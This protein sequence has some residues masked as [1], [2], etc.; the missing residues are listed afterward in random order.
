MK[1]KNRIQV[2]GQRGLARAFVLAPVVF[3][4]VAGAGCPSLFESTTQRETRVKQA[5]VGKDGAYTVP[6]GNTV[7]NVYAQLAGTADPVAGDKSITVTD[8]NGDFL[9]AVAQGD[10]L[11]IVQMAGATIDTTESAT[12]GA[13]TDL[14]SAGRYEFIGVEGKSG[15]TITLACAL[16][17]GYSRAG[18][19]QVIR[20]PQYTTLTVGGANSITAPAW[21]GVTGGVVAVHAETT[22]QLAGTI[23][24]SAK[25]FRGGAAHDS[26]GTTGLA[27][28]YRSTDATTAAEKGESI[29][30]YEA[31]YATG[32]YG[33]GAPANGGGGGGSH[34]AGGGGG[35]NAGDPA[36]YAGGLGVMLVDPTVVGGTL[37]WPLE[38]TTLAN[39][40][41]GGRGGYSYSANDLNGT[42]AAGAPGLAGWGGDSRRV[43]GGLGGHPLANNPASRLFMGGG[44]G[45][46][47]GNDGAAGR[48]G[49]GGGLVFL[50]T[51][52]VT[53]AGSI[54]ADGEAGGNMPAGTANGDAAG[55]GGGG[56]T[57]VVRATTL[58]AITI[59]ADGGKGGDHLGSSSQTEVEGPGGGGGGGYIAL[60]GTGSPTLSAAGGLSGTTT[61]TALS[62]F[63]CDGATVGHAGQT[64]GSA[65]TF[66]YCGVMPVTTIA[67]HPTNPSKTDTGA[68]TFTN[69]VT[70]V[71][72]ECMVDSGAWAACTASFTTGTLADGSHTLSVRATDSNSNREAPPA[73]FTWVI[74]TVAPDTTIATKPTDPS[75]SATG[76]FTFTSNESPV[77][78]ECNL[79][80]G[81]WAACTASTTTPAL[82]NG[83]HT[84]SV[85]ATDAAGNVDA[86]PASYTWVINA[87]LPVTTIANKP[88]NPSKSPTGDFTFTNT[89]NP[90][91]YECKIDTG[92]WASCGASYTTPTLADGSH[93]L[94]VRSSQTVTDAGSNL[95][96]PPV[97]Y[98]WIID[99][100]APDTTIATKPSNPS[101]GS[102]GVFTFESNETPVTFECKLDSGAWALCTASYTTPVLADGSHTLEV[103][104]TDAAKNVDATPA[105][106]TWMV[107]ASGLDGGA[108][109]AGKRDAVAAIDAEPI[110]TV[111]AEPVD[112]GKID[113]QGVD[114]AA[115]RDLGPVLD[116]DKVDSVPADLR[117]DVQAT[118]P[119]PGP[120]TA[121]APTEP[122]AD[123]AVVVKDDAAEPTGNKDA[124]IE[125]V[126]E[127]I[128]IMGGGFCSVASSPATSAA[129]F[130]F[131]FALTGLALLR[132]RR[133]R[134]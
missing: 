95:E 82:P 49:R 100:V 53:G 11:L 56:G 7:V 86:T 51:G 75:A 112:T 29:A 105:T 76:A 107:D 61:R 6:A 64:N 20:V 126:T 122:P 57:V 42:L 129:P 26:R 19:T 9:G 132:R 110:I 17:N 30:G 43:I 117:P 63:P 39:S 106:Y 59:S 91:T 125:P 123:A 50:I 62:E 124:A 133:S 97:T 94:S 60:A 8:V 16:R 18:K 2:A 4:L 13:V 22:V 66:L 41:G 85:R 55:G 15:G 111:D 74:D 47:D 80:S 134:L 128:K 127:N 65:D 44:G 92:A 10:L 46:G 36:G 81:G 25:G 130:A 24:V 99:T 12:Y 72:Y 71:T 119:E 35:A 101:S 52:T 78:F 96:D 73:T 27:A 28:V 32:R 104:A 1:L 45:A 108:V 103:R 116:A 58:S 84:L 40:Q 120:D 98:T 54:L 21:N 3:L 79:D 102:T 131:F 93:T 5:V 37:A 118:G 67:T 31:D 83:S 113:V 14:G 114:L 69:T 70:P 34:N 87:A 33:R 109:D 115:V 23:N 121:P 90:V 68:F 88:D 48:G 89:A 38:V 77:T